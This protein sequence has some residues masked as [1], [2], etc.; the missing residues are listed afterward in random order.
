M[1]PMPSPPPLSSTAM[2][3]VSVCC[4]AAPFSSDPSPPPCSSAISGK[5]WDGWGMGVGVGDPGPL[6]QELR[7]SIRF[8]FVKKGMTTV[9]SWFFN[10]L[11]SPGIHCC[12]IVF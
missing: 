5:E 9:C 2:M 7:V 6:D 1:V 8:E 11:K 3:S 10:W 12:C 4:V